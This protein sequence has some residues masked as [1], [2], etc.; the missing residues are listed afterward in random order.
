MSYPID[1]TQRKLGLLLAGAL[2]VGCIAGYVAHGIEAGP[3]VGTVDATWSCPSG[4]LCQGYPD[5]SLPALSFVQ[6]S[7]PRRTILVG[8]GIS[9]EIRGVLPGGTYRV[10]I[11]LENSMLVNPARHAT[12][13]ITSGRTTHLGVMTPGRDET[14]YPMVCD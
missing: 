2:I 4:T 11:L 5:G 10:A 6:G 13:T 12:V 9:N 8:N 3:G 7:C 1:L 14:P